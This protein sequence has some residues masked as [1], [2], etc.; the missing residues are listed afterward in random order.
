MTPSGHPVLGEKG[1]ISVQAGKFEVNRLGEIYQNDQLIDRIPVYKFEDQ[2][3]LERAGTNL[4]FYGGPE[5]GR[6]PNNEAF[7]M[8]GALE[9]S[10]VNAMKNLTSMIVA[11]RSYEAYQKAISNYDKMMDISNNQLGAVRA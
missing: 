5:S 4:W 1:M 6:T 3:Q 8:Q 7:V 11:H 9:G 10:N 2:A